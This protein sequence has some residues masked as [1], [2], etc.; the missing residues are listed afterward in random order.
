MSI[1]RDTTLSSDS[2]W[3]S[4][5]SKYNVT[6]D[7]LAPRDKGYGW[8]NNLILNPIHEERTGIM[9]YNKTIE[10]PIIKEPVASLTLHYDQC[11]SQ[12]RIKRLGNYAGTWC[13]MNGLTNHENLSDLDKAEVAAKCAR[14]WASCESRG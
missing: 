14:Y 7:P 6:F 1:F 2:Y 11:I 13:P 10:A 4:S 9:E 5:A 8:G 3:Y 12:I